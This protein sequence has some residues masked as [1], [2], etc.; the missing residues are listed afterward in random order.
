[1]AP[2]PPEAA[3]AMRAAAIPRL[4]QEGAAVHR[5]PQ[6]EGRAVPPDVAAVRR[7]LAGHPQAPLVR[8]RVLR[9]QVPRVP[10]G[11]VVHA[12]VATGPVP[13]DEVGLGAVLRQRVT[14]AAFA[15]TRRVL[16][17]TPA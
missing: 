14:N 16:P 1:M 6:D 5:Q 11:A 17:T 8:A 13:L 15:E 4:D 9:P 2:L 3:P 7:L 10:V 12:P